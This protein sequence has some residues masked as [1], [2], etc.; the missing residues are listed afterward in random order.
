[1]SPITVIKSSGEKQALDLDKIRR[2][3]LR[4]GAPVDIAERVASEVQKRAYD[5]IPTHELFS[6]VRVLLQREYPAAARRYNLRDAII[7][8]GP[9]GF[10]F[11]KYIAGLLS[12][13]GYD[14]ELPPILEGICVSHEV[15][16]SIEKNGRTAMIEAKFRHEP[17]VFIN[18][19]DTMA[20]WMRFLDISEAARV[21]RAPHFDE[22]WI[23]TNSRFSHDSISFGHCKNMV[24]LSWDHPH[25]RPLPRWIDEVGLYPITILEKVDRETFP[26][27]SAANIMLL[28]D[29][30]KRSPR[31]LRNLLKLPQN[32]IDE[33]LEEAK[34]VLQK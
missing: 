7:K 20:T 19:K 18:I 26:A 11:E 32:K 12:A 5:G 6:L 33:L 15:D 27:F 14:A 31:E 16:I 30:V 3:V 23:V 8:L 9:A 2:T 24:M 21:G 22:C 34:M 13:Y 10:E 28:Q 25:E 29:F 17:G 1:M 4:S